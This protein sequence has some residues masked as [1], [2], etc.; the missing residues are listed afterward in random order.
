VLCCGAAFADSDVESVQKSARE[1]AQLR[2]EAVRLQTD[3]QWQRQL[4]ATTNG[5]LQDRIAKLQ[6]ERDRLKATTGIDRTELDELATKNATATRSI[7]EA[8]TRLKTITAKLV[9]LRPSLPPRLSQALELPYRSL[10]GTTLS[11]GE[12]MLYVTT[13]L[14]RCAQFNKTITY[15]EE[16]LPLPGQT[17][18]KLL[19]VIYWGLGQGYALDRVTGKAYVGAPSAEGWKWE[20]NASAAPPLLHAFAINQEKADPDFI[21]LPAR[22]A[23]VT[24]KTDR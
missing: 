3:W 1:W 23:H 10:A 15:G 4:L 8:E 16:P 24:T 22:V 19:E 11:P 14:N 17:E 2:S 5:A 13:I 12:R 18:R 21:E 6:S 7:S 9:A 20:E